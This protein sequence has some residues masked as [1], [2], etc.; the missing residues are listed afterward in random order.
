MFRGKP[1]ARP[2]SLEH[3]PL[4]APSKA[5][6]TQVLQIPFQ[7]IPHSCLSLLLTKHTRAQDYSSKV[8]CWLLYALPKCSAFLLCVKLIE[9]IEQWWIQGV[10]QKDS[11]TLS[12]TLLLLNSVVTL[13]LY[14]NATRSVFLLGTCVFQCAERKALVE[15]RQV[16]VPQ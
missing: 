5:T 13:P 6:P 9:T 3:T 4:S 16:S 1:S 11:E 2:P 7:K 15:K 12:L 8:I 10:C 14:F